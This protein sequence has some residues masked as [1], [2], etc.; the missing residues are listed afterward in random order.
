MRASVALYSMQAAALGSLDLPAHRDWSLSMFLD[1]SGGY[2]SACA[3]AIHPAS[4][5]QAAAR[6]LIKII[7]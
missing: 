6:D 5:R 2:V 4:N 3:A 1:T 7:S